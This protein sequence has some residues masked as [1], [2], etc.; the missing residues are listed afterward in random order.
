[1]GPSLLVSGGFFEYNGMPWR[2][3]VRWDGTQ[4]HSMGEVPGAANAIITWTDP[5]GVTSLYIGWSGLHNFPPLSREGIARWTGTEWVS[6]GGG[7]LDP[8]AGLA[9][10]KDMAV[11]DDGSGLALFVAGAF[12][13]AGGASGIL[14]RNIAK[15]D[16]QQWHALGLGIGGGFP[17][18]L[19]VADDGR[20]PSLFVS[21]LFS[22]AGGGTAR[23]IAQWV[24][25]AG[26]RQCYADCDNNRVLNANDFMCFL[27]KYAARDPYANCDGSSASP[28]MTAADFQCFLNK[29][30]QGCP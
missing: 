24:G 13:R 1:M 21:G 29:Y 23:T 11:F 12:S 10:V 22:T 4:W 20:G 15:W 18:Q 26:N 3:L 27:N 17:E 28:V 9:T 2:Y 6:V 25:C 30:A 7:L 16:G 8:S 14:A 19:A 5:S